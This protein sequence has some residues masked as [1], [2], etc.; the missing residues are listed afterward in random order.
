MAYRIQVKFTVDLFATAVLD[1][2][3]FQ[4]NFSFCFI[5][6]AINACLQDDVLWTGMQNFTSAIIV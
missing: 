3:R 5:A 4:K 1:N 6:Q 2:N